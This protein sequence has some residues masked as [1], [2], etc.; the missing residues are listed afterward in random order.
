MTDEFSKAVETSFD[1][2]LA[3]D[4]THWIGEQDAAWQAWMYVHEQTVEPLHAEIARLKAENESANS[5][6]H[7]VAVACATAEQERDQLR[8]EIAGLRTGYEAYERV[9]AELKADIDR[10]NDEYDKAWRHD[11]N[12]KKNVQALAAEVLRLSAESEALRK[13]LADILDLYDTDEG[14]RNLPQYIVGRA[15]LGQGEQS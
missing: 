9:N 15:A 5:R 6:L 14:C 10:L 2:W 11:L 1:T 8:A 7:E 12:D 3:D 4:S 13:A